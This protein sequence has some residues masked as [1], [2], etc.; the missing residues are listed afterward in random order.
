MKAPAGRRTSSPPDIIGTP[1]GVPTAAVAS[2]HD[3]KILLHSRYNPERE[4]RQEEIPACL[5]NVVFLGVGLGYRAAAVL[6]SAPHI[7]TAVV[8]EYYPELAARA[9]AAIERPGLQ[10]H[11]V[12]PGDALPPVLQDRQ[13]TLLSHA[14]SLSANPTWYA[15]VEALVSTAFCSSAMIQPRTKDRLTILVPFEAYYCQRESIR[16]LEALGHRVVTLDYR[17]HEHRLPELFREAIVATPPDLVFCINTRGLDRKGIVA[18]MLENLGIPLS[19]WFVDS[20]EFILYGELLPAPGNTTIFMWERAYIRQIEEMGY[21]VHYLPLAADT[22]LLEAAVPNAAFAAPVGFVGNSLASG[23]LYRLASRFIS[24]PETTDLADRLADEVI[25]HRGNQVEML[26][27]ML[28]QYRHLFDDAD[29]LLFFRAYVLHSGTTKYRTALLQR[30]LSE[31]LVFFGDPDGW[32]RIFGESIDARPD[33]NY[34][35]ETPSVYASVS[36][37]VNATS[38]Q[39]PT[40]VNQRVFDVP[41]CGGFLLTDNQ[42]D[43]LELFAEDE[44]VV[45]RSP[46]EAADKVDFYLRHPEVRRRVVEKARQRVL[47]EHTYRQ[48]MTEVLRVV[49]G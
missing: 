29:K 41:L 14:P 1:T 2:E 45:Y 9:V 11:V 47:G 10:L 22:A 44:T 37:N 18:G 30:L 34:F 5:P 43:V 31:G 21:R 4:A 48:R 6:A 49:L 27:R 23:F 28:L 24:E 13:F 39:M 42:G 15:Q 40:A 19:L 12:T 33:V 20:P 26:D 17:G 36:V 38:L 3:K 35:R 46:A 25:R 32:R 7:T 8:I 16:E